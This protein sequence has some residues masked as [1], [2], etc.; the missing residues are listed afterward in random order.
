MAS[1]GKSAFFSSLPPTAREQVKSS[2]RCP[3]L[4]FLSLF[5]L[6]TSIPREQ[7]LCQEKE[8]GRQKH[9]SVFIL[10]VCVCWTL[11]AEIIKINIYES[12]RYFFFPKLVHF[13]VIN[14]WSGSH[15]SLCI[16]IDIQYHWRWADLGDARLRHV[17]ITCLLYVYP[18]SLCVWTNY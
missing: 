8:E 9:S 3:R 11:G 13:K 2:A 10:C 17:L 18:I 4:F 16:L 5:F 6:N 7:N 1:V 12:S 15:V 14:A